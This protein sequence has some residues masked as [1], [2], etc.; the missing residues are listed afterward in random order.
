MS[1]E[2][3]RNSL[4]DAAVP[5]LLEFGGDL[6]TKQ[7][8]TAAGVAEGTLFR[9]FPDKQALITAII[10]REMDPEPTL[11]AIKGID[12][13][14]S[15]EAVILEVVTVLRSRVERMMSIMHAVGP[16]SQSHHRKA[17][18]HPQ[19]SERGKHIIAATDEA[20]LSTLTPHLDRLRIDPRVAVAF[21]RVSAFGTAMPH[22]AAA[23]LITTHGIADLV[24]RGIVKEESE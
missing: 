14:Q 15:L 3:R 18:Q 19:G 20:I 23:D 1:P 22:F 12:S 2:D 5:L 9:V 13:S 6:T 24:L 4:L 16:H 11:A 21:I 8:A 7:V 10:D 17:G